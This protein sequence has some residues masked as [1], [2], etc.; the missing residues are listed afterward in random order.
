MKTVLQELI[1]KVENCFLENKLNH[2]SEIIDLCK[3]FLGEEKKHIIEAFEAGEKN[4]DFPALHG[5]GKLL[6]ANKYYKQ[7][8]K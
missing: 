4:I 1:E 7:T 2:S 5:Q 8:Y 3:E 6:N